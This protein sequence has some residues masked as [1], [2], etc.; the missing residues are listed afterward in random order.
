MVGLGGVLRIQDEVTK[1]QE[2]FRYF[3]INVPCCRSP[4]NGFSRLEASVPVLIW[5][6]SAGAGLLMTAAPGAGPRENSAKRRGFSDEPIDTI[7]MIKTLFLV[8]RCSFSVDDDDDDDDEDEDEDDD[9]EDDEDDDDGDTDD[10][11]DLFDDH[12]DDDDD[13]KYDD[14][15]DDDDDDEDD[16][17]DDDDDDGDQYDDD[18]DDDEYI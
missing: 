12:D 10:D 5:L 7:L 11:D 18:D 14:D 3:C 17:D 13:D 8:E 1:S 9:D 4:L 6:E 2:D 15:D 16:D